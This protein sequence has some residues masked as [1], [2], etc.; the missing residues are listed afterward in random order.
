MQRTSKRL[1][2]AI[3]DQ[4]KKTK[5]D[6]NVCCCLCL[7]FYRAAVLNKLNNVVPD[8]PSLTIGSVV[9]KVASVKV[10][11]RIRGLVSGST[12]YLAHLDLFRFRSKAVMRVSAIRAGNR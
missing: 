10:R 4:R 8:E 9:E 3:T 7:E 11:P 5:S 2:K 6:G 1:Q 12:T